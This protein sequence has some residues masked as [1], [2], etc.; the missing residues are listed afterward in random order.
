MAG[1]NSA[2]LFRSGQRLVEHHARAAR[3]S[4]DGVDAGV[5]EGLDEEIASHRGGTETGLG[6]L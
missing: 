3:V 5:L 2:D 1:K 4:E 6:S